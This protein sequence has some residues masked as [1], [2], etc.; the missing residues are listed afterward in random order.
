M[1]STP[2]LPLFS[3]LLW[4]IV[5]VPVRVP[6][7][8]HIKLFNHLLYW[9]HLTVCRKTI[10]IK[11]NYWYLIAIQETIWLLTVKWVLARL[12]TSSTKYSFTNQIFNMYKQELTLNNQ[13]RIRET[14]LF[15]YTLFV[16]KNYL[17]LYLLT[18]DYCNYYDKFFSSLETVPRTPITIG[19]P[20][21]LVFYC[22]LCSPARSKYLFIPHEF[23]TPALADEILQESAWLQISSGF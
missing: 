4:R 1:G 11:L 9:N 23:F 16:L 12:K 13:Q 5:I 6:S 3:D 10:A 7:M 17:K 15:V 20:L 22:F 14:I 18:K 19:I 2:S 8:S 21:T